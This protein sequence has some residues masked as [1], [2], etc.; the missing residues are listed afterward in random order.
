[1]LLKYALHADYPCPTE[2][3]HDLAT[4]VAERFSPI[5]KRSNDPLPMITDHPFGP[6]QKGVSHG[7][8]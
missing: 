7:C 1:M 8:S 4:L 2:S 6:Q 3:V 5:L